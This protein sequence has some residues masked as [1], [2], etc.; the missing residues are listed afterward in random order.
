MKCLLFHPTQPLADLLKTL[1]YC[2]LLFYP[3][4]QL[5]SIKSLWIAKLCLSFL[6]SRSSFGL[7]HC[8]TR[9]SGLAAVPSVLGSLAALSSCGQPMERR[10]GRSWTESLLP[11]PCHPLF[12]CLAKGVWYWRNKEM[13]LL[14]MGF[15]AQA[16]VST[17]ASWKFPDEL[18]FSGKQLLD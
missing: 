6:W 17:Q 15:T 5:Y 7:H 1:I 18:L 12:V 14:A 16:D 11:S 3:F 13:R 10:A 2:Y 9:P 4:I 8:R